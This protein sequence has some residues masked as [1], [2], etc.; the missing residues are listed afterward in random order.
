VLAPELVF[1]EVA[2]AVAV[3]VRAKTIGI[4]EARD[5][6]RA[7]IALPLQAVP[8]RLLSVPA[9]E[10]AM[11]GRISAYDACYLELAE[12]GATLVTA[13]RRLARTAANSA[14][15]PKVGPPS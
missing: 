5:V 13:D 12:A 3:N 9:L 14:L 6:L 1:A 10:R 8:L 11:A 15:L 7:T 2:N 4:R